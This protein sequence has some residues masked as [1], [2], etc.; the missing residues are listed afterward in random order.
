VVGCILV[1]LAVISL[2]LDDAL[3]NDKYFPVVCTVRA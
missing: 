1:Y 2:G 3:L